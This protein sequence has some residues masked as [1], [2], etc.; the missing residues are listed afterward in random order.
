MLG[1]VLPGERHCDRLDVYPTAL[2][3]Q[4]CQHWE[5]SPARQIVRVIRCLVASVISG[6]TGWSC[7]FVSVSAVC[8]CWMCETVYSSRALALAY[9]GAQ[10]NDLLLG[11]EA[12]PCK[13]GER[14][15]AA[16]MSHVCLSSG[17]LLP[18]K[19][20]VRSRP[21]SAGQA[22]RRRRS[23]PCTSSWP[24]HYYDPFHMTR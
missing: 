9:L 23:A 21:A 11:K 12:D 7:T 19:N 2:V 16:T 4:R 14:A 1:S 20:R 5:V 13:A 6:T 8:I 18:C 22:A 3:T 10:F 17:H 15:V 24:K